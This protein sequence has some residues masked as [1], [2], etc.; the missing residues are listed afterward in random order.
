MFLS[1]E[2]EDA[3]SLLKML[4]R[5]RLLDAVLT[6]SLHTAAAPLPKL[7]TDTEKVLRER[8]L[9]FTEKYD[10]TAARNLQPTI[11][12]GDTCSFFTPDWRNTYLGDLQL[13]FTTVADAVRSLA[14]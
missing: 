13:L 10:N 2:A 3:T 11:A 9:L 1:N 14:K 5:V 6:S 7:S 12:N 4:H 8:L